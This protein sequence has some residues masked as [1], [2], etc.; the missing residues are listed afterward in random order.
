MR[1]TLLGKMT[2]LAKI[3][4][5]LCAISLGCGALVVVQERNARS[6]AENIRASLAVGDSKEKVEQVMR[7]HRMRP[8][9]S[10]DGRSYIARISAPFRDDISVIVI[11][12]G[13]WQV[14]MIRI[15]PQR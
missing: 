9:V 1:L 5:G 10:G 2:T 15:Q 6:T 11:L 3:V 13:H 7:Y 14:G 12:N 4:T 8:E